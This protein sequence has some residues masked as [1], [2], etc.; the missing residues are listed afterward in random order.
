MPESTEVTYQPLNS[1]ESSMSHTTESIA[2]SALAASPPPQVRVGL[3][4]FAVRR[5]DGQVL[6]GKRKV[7]HGAGTY[8]LPGGHLDYLESFEA[9]A[10]RECLEETGLTL[11]PQSIHFLT[12]TND[13]M[14]PEGKHYVTIFMRGEVKDEEPVPQVQLILWV[15]GRPSQTH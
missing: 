8:Q 1:S 14:P 10:A 15:F 2:P 5:R 4:V 12:A 11:D 13:P 6:V 7:S 3:A 9:C